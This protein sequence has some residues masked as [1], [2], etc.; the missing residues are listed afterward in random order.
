MLKPKQVSVTRMAYHPALPKGQK[1][2]PSGGL[3]K[4]RSQKIRALESD[5]C[6]PLIMPELRRVT[7]V[8]TMP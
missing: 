2:I 8:T 1:T 7:R 4:T 3:S 6:P 5:R